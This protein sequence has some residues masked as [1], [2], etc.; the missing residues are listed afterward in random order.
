MRDQ[1]FE[2]VIAGVIVVGFVC[3][4][5]LAD[6]A[7]VHLADGKSVTVELIAVDRGQVQW[8]PPSS[9]GQVQS[10]LRSQIDHVD[11]PTTPEWREAEEV[12]ESGKIDEAIE[13]YRVVIA[14]AANQYYPM[15][16]N[17]ASLAKLRIMDCYRL[18]MDATAIAKQAAVVRD[19]FSDLPPENRVL[20]PVVLAWIAFSNEKWEGVLSELEQADPPGPEVFLL[21]GMALEELGRDEEAV[22]IYAGG[23]VMNFGGSIN[24]TRAALQRSSALLAKMGNDDR[25]LELKA[26][27]KIYRDLYGKGSLWDGAPEWLTQLADG[28]IETL[29]EID[30]EMEVIEVGPGGG[31]VVEKS[32]VAVMLLPLDE[33]DWT[34]PSEHEKKIHI[35]SGNK[36]ADRS[37][38]YLGGSEFKGDHV[39]FDGTGGGLRAGGFDG[40]ALDYKLVVK[41]RSES[42]D[43]VI[44]ERRGGTDF[45]SGFGLYLVGGKAKFFWFPK[46][47]EKPNVLDL[48]VITVGEPTIIS[49]RI[50]P[51]GVVRAYGALFPGGFTGQVAKEGLKMG[52]DMVISVGDHRP[53]DQNPPSEVWLRSTPFHGAIEYLA[54]TSSLSSPETSELEKERFGGKIM[55]MSPPPPKEE[56]SVTSAEKAPEK[57][58]MDD[59]PVTPEAPSGSGE[60]DWILVDELPEKVYVIGESGAERMSPM[61]RGG[62]TESK[63][64]YVFDGTGGSVTQDGVDGSKKYLR[65]KVRLTAETLNGVIAE[66]KDRNGGLGL[67]LKE[68][69]VILKIARAKENVQSFEVGKVKQGVVTNIGIGYSTKF[70]NVNVFEGAE[71]VS[72]ERVRLAGKPDG[73]RIAK[74][75]ELV[76]GASHPDEARNKGWVK[77]TPFKGQIHHFSVVFADDGKWASE[78]EE[79]VFDG[80][81][82]RFF[83]PETE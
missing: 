71:T 74:S 31:T 59:K 53:D 20:E 5:C 16:G 30:G 27:V 24:L 14:D 36:K 69:E 63:T 61:V 2:R 21:N 40:A 50:N 42:P 49:L 19:E 60:I 43:G 15:P 23:Y 46:E 77:S 26:Q 78:N 6:F 39:W 47:A 56:Q 9:A 35:I 82:I 28:E 4:E 38:D 3:S 73:L 37:I 52:P 48:G 32:A 11:F 34:L 25:T 33:R 13:K 54:F 7:T 1:F 64:S 66:I 70:V 83:P 81:L 22:Q 10:F 41:F 80:K 45:N 65:I 17:F 51:V 8:Q 44:Y 75:V 79:K 72:T 12:F 76:I 18:Q 62:V 67:Y 29:G 55:K 57:G 68:G 58:A